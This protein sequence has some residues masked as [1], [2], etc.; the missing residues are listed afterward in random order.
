MKKR[1]LLL[2]LGIVPVLS[3][4]QSEYTFKENITYRADEFYKTDYQKE[5]CILDTYIPEGGSDFPTLVYFHG[6]G[7]KG[8]NKNIP[9]YLKG[10]GIAVIAANY[11]FFPQVSTDVVVDDAAAAVA[12]TFNNIEALGGSKEKIFLS[13]HS[14]GGYL[15]SMLGLDKHF[16]AKYD[17]DA[18]QIA[19][20]IPLS[21]HT[22]TH[23]TVR[24]ERNIGPLKPLVDEWAP[25][26]HVR[27]DAPPYIMITGD[28]ELEMLGRYEENA[29]MWRMMQLVK[30]PQTELH[31][32][33]GYGHMMV[34]PAIPIVVRKIKELTKAID[35]QK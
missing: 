30:H 1:F 5:R 20:L 8:G 32:I 28:R 18:D 11:R 24:E 31:E 15:T 29:Y 26:Y 9:E 33:D 16:L 19:G 4:A 22:I 27:A 13:G 14:A 17:I 3:F 7:L 6:G 12:W 35:A 10:K 23:M 34:Y 25:L 21:G 2:I